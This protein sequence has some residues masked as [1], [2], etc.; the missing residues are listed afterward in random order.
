[1]TLFHECAHA[2]LPR[3]PRPY[4]GPDI[5][6]CIA[7]FTALGVCIKLGLTV[8]RNQMST[9]VYNA[10][11]THWQPREWFETPMGKVVFN[12]AEKAL[13]YLLKILIDKP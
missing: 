8:D 12:E 10:T 11:G 1:M 3:I 7:E 2:T 6:E 13:I 9:Y 5:E 4:L